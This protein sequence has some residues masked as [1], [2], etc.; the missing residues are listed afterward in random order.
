[1]TPITEQEVV[2]IWL[3]AL[4]AVVFFVGMIVLYFGEKDD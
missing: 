3:V 2:T 4:V 1:M